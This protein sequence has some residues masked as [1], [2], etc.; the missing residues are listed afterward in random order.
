MGFTLIDLQIKGDIIPQIDTVL[1]D[2]DGVLFDVHA[3]WGTIIE[4]RAWGIIQK[5][6]LNYEELGNLTWTMGLRSGKLSAEG[7]TGLVGEKEIIWCV[8]KFLLTRFSIVTA[9]GDIEDIFSMVKEDL[10]KN[11]LHLTCLLPHAFDFVASLYTKSI[12]MAIVTN[13]YADITRKALQSV[14]VSHMIPVIIGHET[15]RA[16]K[17]T[18]T[19]AQQA[20]WKLNSEFENTVVIGATPSDIKMAVACSAASGIAVGTGQVSQLALLNYTP[21]VVGNLSEI[22]IRSSEE[23]K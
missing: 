18:G 3:W 1:F 21:F 7:P 8:R 17:E 19:P 13:D 12:K 6:N 11:E 10:K 22:T 4:R 20:M 9:N 5:Y 23:R 16:T 15:I 2:K 14:G